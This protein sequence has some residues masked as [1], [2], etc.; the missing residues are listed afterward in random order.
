M[1]ETMNLVKNSIYVVSV[2]AIFLSGCQSNKSKELGSS[3]VFEKENIKKGEQIF[4]SRCSSCHSFKNKGIGPNLSGLTRTV[5]TDWIKDFISDSKKMVDKK[6]E[7][8]IALFEKYK[9]YMPNFQ[10]LG[11][12]SI[13]DVLSYMHTFA[14]LPNVDK[15]TLTSLKNPITETIKYSGMLAHLKLIA[16]IPASD[17]TFPLAR[18]NK[19]GCEKSS[20]RL[21]VNDLRGFLYELK[22]GK[23]H[24]FFDLRIKYA[25]FYQEAGLGSGFGSFAFHPD[26]KN[27]GL[28]YTTH[29]ESPSNK[30]ADFP[31]PENITPK[32]QWVLTEW[33]VDDT[34]APTFSGTQKEL[35]RIDFVT[36]G[37]GLQEI[38]FNPTVD[39]SHPDFGMLYICVGDGV[40]VQL[41]YSEL[42]DHQAKEIW[43]TILRIDPLG[44]NSYNEKYGIPTDNPMFDSLDK[45]KEIWAYGFRNPNR[46]AWDFEG[47][48]L[49]TDIGQTHIEELNI[50][51]AGKCYGWPIREG[52]FV[53]EPKG[54]LDHIYPLP[55]NDS[56]FGLTY[57]I[58]AYDHDEGPAI[59]GGYMTNSNLI[60]EKYIFG[61]I[62]TGRFFITDLNQTTQAVIQELRISVDN[63]ITDLYAM[64]KSNR[65]D[66]KFGSD[67]QSNIYAFT[68]ADGRVYKIVKLE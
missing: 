25:N 31:L 51:E 13:K 6:D 64:T 23:A 41:G 33:H 39:K 67:C 32:L 4:N 54:N 58:V 7:R 15:D 2:L 43:G 40:S 56:I 65:V 20:G 61:D 26:F 44:S 10:D 50:I 66:L 47:R 35:M 5:E 34:S 59:S 27:N 19:I 62:P 16:Q 18:I 49:A 14:D 22:D 57:P 52:R 24:L 46:F 21:F 38:A 45:R 9:V 60:K 30:L 3:I 8:A 55:A 37:H 36:E 63:K 12:Q 28:F 29:S 68:K 48:L 11:E 42:V 17:D 1:I 53:I